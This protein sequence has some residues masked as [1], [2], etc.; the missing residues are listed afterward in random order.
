MA[1]FTTTAMA[2]SCINL[3]T[4]LQLPPSQRLPTHWKIDSSTIR[5]YDFHYCCNRAM[6]TTYSPLTS[7]IKLRMGGSS[8]QVVGTG[9]VHMPLDKGKLLILRDVLC[10]PYVMEN[11]ISTFQLDGEQFSA[12]K[13]YLGKFDQSLAAR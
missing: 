10:I 6:F 5:G 1:S 11:S 7:T 2:T 3:R 9:S 4:T 12:L 8:L 13:A